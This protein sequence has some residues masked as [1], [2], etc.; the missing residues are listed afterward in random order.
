MR[1]VFLHSTPGNFVIQPYLPID[2]SGYSL[3]TI[4]TK[5]PIDM[6]ENS[7]FNDVPIIIGK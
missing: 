6:I 2:D 1:N 4:F 3:K 7:E 5:D